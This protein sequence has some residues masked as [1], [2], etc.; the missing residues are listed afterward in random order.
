ML[1]PLHDFLFSSLRKI[2]EDSTFDQDRKFSELL[3]S[4]SREKPK[5]YGFD[6]SAATDRLPIVLQQDILSLIGFNLP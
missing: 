3:S 4:L 1:R 2:G 5:L 6:L